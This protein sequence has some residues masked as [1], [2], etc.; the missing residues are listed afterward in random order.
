MQA[1]LAV[2][3][4]FEWKGGVLGIF[5]ETENTH[6]CVCVYSSLMLDTCREQ[7]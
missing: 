6:V 3:V 5:C 1:T 2:I 7:G 4:A